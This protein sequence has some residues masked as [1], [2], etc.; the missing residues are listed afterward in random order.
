ML[1]ATTRKPWNFPGARIRIAPFPCFSWQT[2]SEVG[3]GERWGKEE[4]LA[5]LQLLLRATAL[6]F[7]VG[8]VTRGHGASS[9]GGALQPPGS[10]DHLIA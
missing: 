8:V 7:F 10:A 5:A 2:E 6:D 3:T 1:V 4:V 9:H